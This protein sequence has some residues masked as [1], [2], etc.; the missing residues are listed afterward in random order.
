MALAPARCERRELGA[1]RLQQLGDAAGHLAAV[2]RRGFG[3]T[4]TG[5]ARDTNR[6]AEIL[7]RRARDVRAL[8]DE[9]AAR[10]R[11][12]ERAADEQLVGLLHRQPFHASSSLTY[13]SSP[14]RPPSRPKPD[15]L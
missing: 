5:L 8:R 4:D 6:V 7:A 11:T 9:R 13:A 15:S 3:P 12:R 2:V 14:W 1:P 10:L